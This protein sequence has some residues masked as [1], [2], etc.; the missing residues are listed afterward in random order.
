MIMMII[1]YL[2][3]APYGNELL[4]QLIEHLL[5]NSKLWK[6]ADK[7]VDMHFTSAIW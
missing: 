1:R 4:Q 5:M 6:K 2:S 7:K 3:N